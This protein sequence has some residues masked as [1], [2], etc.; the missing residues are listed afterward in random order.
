MKQVIRIEN[1][2]YEFA[3]HTAYSVVVGYDSR[4]SCIR[5]VALQYNDGRVE[6]SA[7]HPKGG[8]TRSTLA[9]RGIAEYGNM[10]DLL[11]ALPA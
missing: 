8:S 7:T 11:A 1:K 10:E 3:N 9:R 2:M 5:V 4:T 6:Y